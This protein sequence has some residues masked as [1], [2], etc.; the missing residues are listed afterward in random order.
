MQ[1]PVS[2]V[3]AL[4]EEFE[5]L[6]ADFL[7]R[8][9]LIPEG[10]TLQSKRWMSRSVAPHVKALSDLFNRI[11]GTQTDAIDEESY[12]TES[13]SPKNRRLAYLLS[14]MPPNLFR[15]A[16]IWSEL[17]RLGFRWPFPADQDFRGIEFGA[18]VASGACGV[19]AGERH[20]PIGMPARGNFALIEQ[21]KAALQLGSKWLEH[22][23]GSSVGSRPFHRRVDL[24]S[25][26][27][28]PAAPEFHVFVFSYF[29]NESDLPAGTLVERFLH[30]CEHHLADEGLVLISE[31]ALRLQ[32]RKLL[33]FRKALIEHP[34]VRSGKAGLKVLLPCLGHQACGALVKEDDWCHEEVSWW[35]PPYLRE[36]DALTGLDRKSLPFSYLVIQKTRRP[37]EEILPRLKGPAEERYRL[38]SPS[39][40]L[41]KR[42]SEFFICG[43]EGKRRA[44]LDGAGLPEESG[45]PDRGSILENTAL[46]G[47]PSLSQITRASVID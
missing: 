39:H 17:H 4:K 31:P 23:S 46:H 3:N 35:R 5:P 11:E 2:L 30:T 44:R 37:L 45:M 18:G 43:Q 27:L 33:E 16:A 9:K 6:L 21:S 19:V 20:A 29:L 1:V 15:V 14:F 8:E 10:E 26:W 36:L 32:S 13:G 7:A 41:S 28:P 24:G 25:T 38:V 34:E 40:R 12:W 42:T 22:F 47:D